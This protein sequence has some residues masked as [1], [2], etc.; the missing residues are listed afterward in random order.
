MRNRRRVKGEIA[1]AKQDL[2]AALDRMVRSRVDEI[3]AQRDS[4]RFE[5]DFRQLFEPDFRP[6]SLTGEIFKRQTVF[7]RKKWSLYYADWGCRR[8]DR[9]DVP[10]QALGYCA[11]CFGLITQRLRLLRRTW[12][13]EHP[14][15]QIEIS[16]QSEVAKR[17]LGTLPAEG[18]E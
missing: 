13:R 1:P 18:E 5:P 9:K 6:R 2:Q 10:H 15:Q 7:D 11:K 16:N 12:D 4:Q 3:M 14:Q 8:C 17:V